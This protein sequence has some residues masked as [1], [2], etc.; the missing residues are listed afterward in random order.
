MHASW[1][2][3]LKQICASLPATSDTLNPDSRQMLPLGGWLA[4]WRPWRGAGCP[5][6]A[7]AGRL[8]CVEVQGRTKWTWALA[9]NRSVPGWRLGGDIRGPRIGWRAE[10]EGSDRPRRRRWRKPGWGASL[11]GRCG[12]RYGLVPSLFGRGRRDAPPRSGETGGKGCRPA[13]SRG[14]HPRGQP[15]MGVERK[16]QT[17]PA[18]ASACGRQRRRVCGR[19]CGPHNGG[20]MRATQFGAHA[21][22]RTD[23]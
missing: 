14:R 22:V 18:L 23:R 1:R 19:E 16:A 9:E 4:G 20:R 7:W 15:G 13:G 3:R 6:G 17:A 2:R 10:G 11:G 5:G 8:C 12:R 21:N